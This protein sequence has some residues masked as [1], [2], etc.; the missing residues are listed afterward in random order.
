MKWG[1]SSSTLYPRMQTQPK[2]RPRVLDASEPRD[3]IVLS[4]L[5][6][7]RWQSA[8]NLETPLQI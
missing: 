2:S 5:R 1:R 7:I 6:I 4:S 8:I 3:F